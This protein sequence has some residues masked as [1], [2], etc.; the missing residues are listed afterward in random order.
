MVSNVHKLPR[1][2]VQVLPALQ[3]TEQD[4]TKA[5]GISRSHLW[6]G[7]AKGVYPPPEKREVGNRWDTATVVQWYDAGTPHFSRWIEH[8]T[9]EKT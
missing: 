9:V 7:I 3:M 1:V 2:G 6:A 8:R 5:L 4:L